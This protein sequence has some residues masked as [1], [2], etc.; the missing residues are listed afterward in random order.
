V[1]K[2]MNSDEFVKAFKLAVRDGVAKDTVS[3]LESPPGRR[4][5]K[6]LVKMSEFYNNLKVEEREVVNRPDY[7]GE[8]LV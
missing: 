1:E 6:D 8:L 7:L 4:P 3:V 5:P 2:K